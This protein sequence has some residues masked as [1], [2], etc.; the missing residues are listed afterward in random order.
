MRHA[1]R[2]EPDVDLAQ[3]ARGR[4]A[5]RPRVQRRRGPA[6][7]RRRDGRAGRARGDHDA[8]GRLRRLRARRRPRASAYRVPDRR[9]RE[10]VA[11]VGAGDAFLAGYVAARYA[12]QPPADCL[13]FGVACGAESTQHLGA[14]LVD[15]RE[16]ERL[17]AESRSSAVGARRSALSRAARGSVPYEARC[18]SLRRVM[19]AATSRRTAHP[20]PRLRG[21]FSSAPRPRIRPMEIEIGRGKKARRAYGFD[22]IAI[23]PS[24]R[25][26]DPDDVDISWKLGD[27]R[28]ELPLLASAMDGV[29]SP[30]HGGHHRQARRP[31]RPEPRGHLHPLRGRRR[32]ARAHRHA[33][34]GGRDARDAGD[35]PR[36]DQARS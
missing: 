24:R 11:G 7:R 6:D 21:V 30:A 29:V 22:D 33:A 12:G 8:P 14:G 23:V 2:A 5:R 34:Q 27:Y 35:L 13:R 20:G 36:A 3:R 19:V 18:Y 4:G 26:R 9:T 15:P 32:A 28:F 10:A 31:R 1:V 25:T 17:L 16:V